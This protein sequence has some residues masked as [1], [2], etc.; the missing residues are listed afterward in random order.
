MIEVTT[1]F[2][3][4]LADLFCPFCGAK[5]IAEDRQ[6]LPPCPHLAFI[7]IGEIDHF[8]FAIPPIEQAVE[9]AWSKALD[10]DIDI[11]KLAL[12]DS[13]LPEKLGMTMVFHTSGMAC[14]PVSSTFALGFAFKP[15]LARSQ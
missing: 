10:E 7:Y 12:A 5:V 9:E 6:E 4:F 1:P 8:E 3:V 11:D 13:L 15:E 14:G 2:G